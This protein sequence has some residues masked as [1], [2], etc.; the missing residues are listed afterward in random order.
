[1]GT[2]WSVT[3]PV[4]TV[5]IPTVGHRSR[6]RPQST[7]WARGPPAANRGR[8]RLDRA[9]PRLTGPSPDCK[10]VGGWP[11]LAGCKTARELDVRGA[12]R[13]RLKIRAATRV[14]KTASGRAYRSKKTTRSA[15]SSISFGTTAWQG[16]SSPSVRYLRCHNQGLIP[17]S[18]QAEQEAAKPVHSLNRG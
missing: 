5:P 12:R 2:P 1:V 10:R 14:R 18:A 9:E 6:H 11:G 15:R 8:G 3:W 17:T 16:R 7:D 13:G 4:A